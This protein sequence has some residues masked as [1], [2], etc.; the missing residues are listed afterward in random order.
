MENQDV[1][2]RYTGMDHHFD[3]IV[4]NVLVN[5]HTLLHTFQKCPFFS[6]QNVLRHLI[7]VCSICQCL[8]YKTIRCRLSKLTLLSSVSNTGAE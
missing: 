8:V 7:W 5:K 3:G 4:Q 2:T 6:M 1:C